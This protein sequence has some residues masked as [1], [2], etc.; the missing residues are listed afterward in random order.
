LGEGVL[1]LNGDGRVKFAN[2]RL[3]AMLGVA[4]ADLVG[5][6]GLET[7]HPDDK[8]RVL[9]AFARVLRRDPS[10][11]TVTVR[12]H[13]HDGTTLWVECD[14]TNL[15]AESAVAGV[16]AS[17]REVTERLE[18]DAALTNAQERFRA[19]FEHAP[20]GMA[21]VK[22]DGTLVE[23]NG[24]FTRMLGYTTEELLGRNIQEL[25]HPDDWSLDELAA[26]RLRR[27]PGSNYQLERRYIRADGR[28]LWAALSFS[29]VSQA[30][31][32]Q[33]IIGQ[34]ED[35]TQRKAI[36]ERLEYSARH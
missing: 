11:G 19:A 24:A 9:D 7:V 23:V 34:I 16:V 4:P 5:R 6:F 1:I 3:G 30:D 22:V 26:P 36:A 14:A 31:G 12:L 10:Q 29:Y 25:T 8:E 13:R 35:I 33:L 15:L 20:I 18:A 28:I 17:I 27:D 21:L 2:Q 32:S